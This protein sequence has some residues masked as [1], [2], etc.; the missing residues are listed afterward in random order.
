MTQDKF[1]S[2][3]EILKKFFGIYCHG[4][5]H[6]NIKVQNTTLDFQNQTFKYDF[7]LC[8]ECFKLLEYSFDRLQN[9]PHDEKPKCRTCPNPCYEPDEWKK[10]AKVMKYAGISQGIKK[11]KNIFTRKESD[12]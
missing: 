9:C 2:E 6:N 1:I 12:V 10:V 5:K 4:K 8:N 7:K 11:I 3:V